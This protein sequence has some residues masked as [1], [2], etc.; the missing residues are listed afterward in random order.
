LASSCFTEVE[1]AAPFLNNIQEKIKG[2]IK[3][4]NS[5]STLYNFKK[6]EQE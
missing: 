4:E 3:Y 6:E 5:Q 1:P 2:K